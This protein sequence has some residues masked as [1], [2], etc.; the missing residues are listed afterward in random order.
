MAYSTLPAPGDDD[1]TC[2]EPCK[3]LDCQ[4]NR[5]VAEHVCRLCGEPIGFG[6]KFC[7][8]P[9]RLDGEI[10]FV[11]ALREADRRKDEAR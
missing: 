2:P 8:D 7:L 3:H 11:C 5:R 10:H 9:Y 6:V 1:A 4:A